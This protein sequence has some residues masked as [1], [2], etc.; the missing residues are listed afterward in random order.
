MCRR[1][2]L[3]RIWFWWAMSLVLLVSGCADIIMQSA[4]GQVKVMVTTDPP[5][6][7]IVLESMGSRSVGVYYSPAEIIYYPRPNMPTIIT[8]SKKG[9]QTKRVRLEPGQDH[10]HV[11]LEKASGYTL[12]VPGG[13]GALGGGR[14][15]FPG[16]GPGMG[17]G[18]PFPSDVPGASDTDTGTQP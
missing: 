4:P 7:R 6:S 18:I 10:I 2:F 1:S 3:W 13:M 15:G 11:V 17:G 9:Y 5:N 8:V 16:G 12:D 14:G